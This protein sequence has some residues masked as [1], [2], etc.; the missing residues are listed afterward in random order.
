MAEHKKSPLSNFIP[1]NHAASQDWLASIWMMPFHMSAAFWQNWMHMSD[2]FCRTV[3][4]PA[5][6]HGHEDHNQLE[7]P[8]PLADDD[9][10]DLFA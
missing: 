9:E 8:D 5:K 1:V 3:F 2:D 10:H 7:V 6:F 4:R